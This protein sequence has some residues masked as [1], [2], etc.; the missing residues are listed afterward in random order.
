METSGLVKTI[1]E[2]QAETESDTAKQ[3][4]QFQ[5]QMAMAQLSELLPRSPRRRPRSKSSRHR[6]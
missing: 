2:I 4:A 1:Q 5:Q 6:P 3:A